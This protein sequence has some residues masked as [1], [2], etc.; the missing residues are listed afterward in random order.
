MDQSYLEWL[1]GLPGFTEATARK[2]A[3]RFPTYERLE[4]ATRGELASLVVLRSADVDALLGVL[5]GTTPPKASDELFLCPECGSF[6]GAGA[7]MPVL[8]RP[9][10]R[11]RGGRP[12]RGARGILGGGRP[13]GPPLPHV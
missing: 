5:H 10:R 6:V 1:L 9:V 11:I 4:T 7:T 2:V 12:L 8:R 13:P 3:E